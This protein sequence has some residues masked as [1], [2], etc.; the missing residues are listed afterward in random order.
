MKR[1]INIGDRVIAIPIEGFTEQLFTVPARRKFTGEVGVVVS[2]E[3]ETYFVEF[4]I[5][6]GRKKGTKQTIAF[7]E[8]ELHWT[9]R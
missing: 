4:T 1:P 8:R 7:E 2:I 5:Q 9:D 6:R 3:G